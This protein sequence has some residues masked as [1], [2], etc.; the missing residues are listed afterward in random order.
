MTTV[1]M[2]SS[3]TSTSSSTTS[4][5]TTTIT[6]TSSPTSSSTSTTTSTSSGS[7]STTAT[8]TTTTTVVV[9]PSATAVDC[10]PSSVIVGSRIK[11]DAT[12]TGS[13]PTGV[14]TWSTSGSGRFSGATCRLQN[15]TCGVTYTATA[16]S[17]SETITGAYGGDAHNLPSSGR[18]TL[19]VTAKASRTAV[20]C[21]PSSTLAGSSQVIKC[22]ASVVGYFPTGTVVWSQVGGTGSVSFTSSVCNLSQERCAVTMRAVNA[23][24]VTILAHYVG[25]PNNQGSSKNEVLIILPVKTRL[26]I[27]CTASS[28]NVGSKVTCTATLAGYTG[29]IAGDEI[30]W[31][32]V[33]GPGR[34]SFSRAECAL[35]ASGTCSVTV[36]GLT[37][38]GLQIKASYVGDHDNLR[39]T[40]THDLTV[41]RA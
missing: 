5:S 37:A 30:T 15:G 26:A 11:C 27:S 14:V 6:S 39:S 9:V 10:V 38:G 28:M 22:T 13:S 36:T 18:F 40:A 41:K 3:T 24:S 23:G 1:S 25:D 8:V 17:P 20:S 19:R 16:G 2:T 12:V 31:S 34:V 21:S 29:S 35:S 33:S 7:S 32:Q 4:T